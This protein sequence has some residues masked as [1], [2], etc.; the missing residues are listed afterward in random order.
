MSI[1]SAIKDAIF[2]HA[3]AAAPATPTPA[4]AAAQPAHAAASA[5]SAAAPAPATAPTQAA[6][7]AGPV[8]VEAVL[9]GM[10]GSDNLN[11]RTSIVDLMKLL[12]IDSSLDEPQGARQGA[13]LFRRAGR[14]GRN[15]HLAAQ[16][17]DE[18]ARRERRQSA[19]RHARLTE[20]AG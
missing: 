19:R 13:R 7:P 12:G 15:E 2:G 3:K 20:V 11:W 9:G 1:F 6:A 4:P 10:P 5:S 18:E 14:F 16:G 8:D 17:D